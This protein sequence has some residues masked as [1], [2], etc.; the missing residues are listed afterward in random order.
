MA[1]ATH[2]VRVLLTAE[3]GKLRRGLQDGARATRRLRGAFDG[4]AGAGDRMA[5]RA[6]SAA[7]RTGRAQTEAEA[8]V[9]RLR[10]A[11]TGAGEKSTA[12]AGKAEA[13][14]ERV[15]GAQVEA[16][17]KV[18]RL[19]AA[20]TGAG[21]KS[22]A[23]AGK[24]EAAG[25][26]VEGAQV[27]AEAKV[28]RLAGAFLTAGNRATR[29]GDKAVAA[30]R[31]IV[32]AVGSL[33][34]AF[35]LAG[36]AFAIG[37]SA[38]RVASIETRMERLGIQSQRSTEEMTGLREE[39]YAV[40]NAPDIRVDPSQLTS[41]VEAIVEKTGDLEFAQSNLRLIAEAIQGSGGT[42]D[43]LGRL[44]AEFR[45][46]GITSDDEV[47]RML[48]LLVV[49]GKTGAFTLGNMAAQGE[50]LFSAFAGLGYEG[51]GAVRQLGAI[52]QMAR[53]A[54]GSSEQA[55]TAT[56][57]LLRTLADAAKI[58][59]IES[60]LG[61]QVRTGT[62]DYRALD[63]ILTDLV[64]AVGGDIVQL[65]E[66]FDAEA[67]RVLNSLVTEEGRRG[68]RGFLGI[69]AR[70]D[71]LGVDAA[72][73]AQTTEAAAQD[74]RTSFEDKL[75]EHL[76]GPLRDVSLGLAEFQGEIL[77]AAGAGFLAAGAFKAV[78]GGLG[79]LSAFKAGEAAEG[80][81]E[82]LGDTGAGGDRG[83]ESAKRGRKRR[84]DPD[85]RVSSMR[86]GTMRVSRMVG[87]GGK[88]GR[89]G[90]LGDAVVGGAA[91]AAAGG[92]DRPSG[93]APR[94]GLARSLGAKALK[95]APFVG[96][97]IVAAEIVGEVVDALGVEREGL[98][99]DTRRAYRTRR[100][101]PV[102]DTEG[103]TTFGVPDDSLPAWQRVPPREAPETRV[104]SRGN[105][106]Y[107]SQVVVNVQSD[108]ADPRRVA[109]EVADEIERRQRAQR[110]RLDDAVVADGPAEVVF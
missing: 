44:T 10:A 40:A 81:A 91:G 88:G 45:K 9:K 63:A 58:D 17:A 35:G 28:K 61:V 47:A 66:I 106:R 109:E 51:P 53:Q 23:M 79:L 54:T 60:E 39:I 36:G 33:G 62:G 30:R 102:P 46:L 19:R 100:A 56:E 65:S 18:K 74:I 42:G 70:G 71:E 73:I 29:M 108:S 31:R 15:E 52:S 82:G 48:N 57:A 37:A 14:G 78:K 6:T 2:K 25:E 59:K 85:T 20:F 34:A 94:G 93:G 8:K 32:G 96:G 21:E 92:A 50:R 38:K 98:D 67:I 1:D 76:T 12:M 90:G 55:T 75:A 110:V 72:R 22:T 64:S 105:I 13:A 95:A 80:V 11:F 26:R 4:A 16:E 41:A 83:E 104:A 5:E 43:A 87:G 68:Y 77:A 97:A 24:A 103:G 27:E 86:V 3:A 69:E 89:R 101:F 84:G 99:P 7:A 107:R 49:Q